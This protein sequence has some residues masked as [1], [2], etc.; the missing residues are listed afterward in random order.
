MKIAILIFMLLVSLGASQAFL[1]TAADQPGQLALDKR[2]L[3]PYF[4]KVRASQP[5]VNAH[6]KEKEITPRELS[7][8]MKFMMIFVKSINLKEPNMYGNKQ[9]WSI[10]FG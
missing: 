1:H 3:L 9:R 4:Q 6:V 2:S 5:K 7:R 8:L 10:K